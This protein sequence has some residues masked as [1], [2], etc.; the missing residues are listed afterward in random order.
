MVVSAPTGRVRV[1]RGPH[2]RLKAFDTR[3]MNRRRWWR[4]NAGWGE[5][6]ASFSEG[7]EDDVETVREG[8]RAQEACTTAVGS[9]NRPGWTRYS[10]QQCFREQV[11]AAPARDEA[12]AADAA[13][14]LTS[15][16]ESRAVSRGALSARIIT[17]LK[18]TCILMAFS[19]LRTNAERQG[20]GAAGQ[21]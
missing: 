2:A 16:V 17:W 14:G 6:T 7:A 13:A 8:W 5:R 4:W 11:E 18:R 20:T 21:A 19:R 10:V 12:G 9:N 1:A 15:A 3:A